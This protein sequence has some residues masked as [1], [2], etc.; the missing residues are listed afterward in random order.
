MTCLHIAS[1]DSEHCYEPLTGHT[2]VEIGSKLV[3]SQERITKPSYPLQPKTKLAYHD[4]P[5]HPIKT[6]DISVAEEDSS[7]FEKG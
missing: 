4:I 5:K 1:P 3:W 2:S 7:L 6:A